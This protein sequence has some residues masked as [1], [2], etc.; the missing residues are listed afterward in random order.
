MVKLQFYRGQGGFDKKFAIFQDG[1]AFDL[2]LLSNPTVRW[3]FKRPDETKR[4]LDWNGV[5]G[6]VNNNEATI[7]VTVNFFNEKIIYE[8]QI[9]VFDGVGLVFHNQ[10]K[11][12]VEIL[13][14][15]G[16]HTDP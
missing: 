12:I 11:L 1:V 10:E 8:S 5:P 2:S 3:H 6:G 7:T 16:V 13:E 15:S 9:E 4:L 14:P